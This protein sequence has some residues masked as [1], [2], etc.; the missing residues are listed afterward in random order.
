LLE[1]VNFA[2]IS[3][4]IC[5]CRFFCFGCRLSFFRLRGKFRCRSAIVSF[6][7]M[8]N[9]C[10]SFSHIPVHCLQACA[11]NGCRCKIRPLAAVNL[12]AA[13][14]VFNKFGCRRAV[15]QPCKW[16]KRGMEPKIGFALDRTRLI[17]LNRIGTCRTERVICNESYG[18][19]YRLK[20]SSYGL[21][22][23][24]ACGEKRNFAGWSLDRIR[25]ACGTF[26]P[27]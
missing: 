9:S 3:Y 20:I 22:F 27:L 16:Y 18:E 23:R 21:A 10:Q 15:G 6:A 25:S 14:A 7:I 4:I 2:N 12:T 11:E 5:G 1:T 24:E 26:I 17:G 8:S 13:G 19:T